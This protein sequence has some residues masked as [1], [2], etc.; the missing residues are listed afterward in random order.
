MNNEHE[1]SIVVS[2][3]SSTHDIGLETFITTWFEDL[4]SGGGERRD[5][6]DNIENMEMFFLMAN[7]A[8]R[9]A[10][11]DASDE[12]LLLFS[13]LA[14]AREYFREERMEPVIAGWGG[15]WKY[16]CD[17]FDHLHEVGNEEAAL[18]LVK[19]VL[20]GM[21]TQSEEVEQFLRSVWSNK[22]RAKVR[23]MNAISLRSSSESC[24]P[25]GC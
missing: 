8:R 11:P 13:A 25:L 19:S 21:Q 20:R 6:I 12:E 5:L 3:D 9:A 10:Q 15:R 4:R 17:A 7:I 16:V 22:E 18:I 23:R 14:V 24:G 2:P 1:P